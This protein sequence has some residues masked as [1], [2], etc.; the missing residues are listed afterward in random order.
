MSKNLDIKVGKLVDNPIIRKVEM[1]TSEGGKRTAE[2]CNNFISMYTRPNGPEVKVK[3]EAW[4]EVARELVKH[5][6]N[7]VIYMVG[8]AKNME[9][10][11]EGTGEKYTALGYEI[12]KI[13]PNKALYEEIN[14][15]LN[16]HLEAG[17]A[18]KTALAKD[19]LD[20]SGEMMKSANNVERAK[21]MPTLPTKPEPVLTR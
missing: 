6:K 16:D 7:D 8:K 5:R 2:V 9:Y 14:K 4:G 21:N 1:T 20:I 3:I 18:K 17:K 13:E 19:A 12:K 15:V 10:K 11:M